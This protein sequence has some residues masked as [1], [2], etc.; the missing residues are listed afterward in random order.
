MKK[1]INPVWFALSMLLCAAIVGLCLFAGRGGALLLRPEGSPQD[2]VRRFFEGVIAGDWESAY[3]CL[4]DYSGLGLEHEPQSDSAK[5]LCRALRESYAYSL[6]G[7]C[8]VDAL[9][10][11]QR[12]R[13]RYLDLKAVEAEI[14]A[15]VE[16]VAEELVEE[17]SAPEIY[18]DE[19]AYLESF[20]DDVYSAALSEVLRSASGYCSEIE[21]EL[22][23]SYRDG[24]WRLHCSNALFSALLG[25][26]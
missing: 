23:L 7:D 2:T 4:A 26:V 9:T 3:A 25:G 24:A 11:T 21:L 12:V 19:G 5:T 17:R 18:D 16:G 8:V 15:R 14:A 13:L 20:T 10:A 1:R 6:P 22:K